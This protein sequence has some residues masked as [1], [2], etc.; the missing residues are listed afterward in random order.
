MLPF[1]GITINILHILYAVSQVVLTNFCYCL[2]TILTECLILMLH[3]PLFLFTFFYLFMLFIDPNV[4]K[5]KRHKYGGEMNPHTL[6]QLEELE[7]LSKYQPLY[8]SAGFLSQAHLPEKIVD[9]SIL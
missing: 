1:N 7:K 9:K 8:C 3:V 2:G 4:L 5:R 6:Q